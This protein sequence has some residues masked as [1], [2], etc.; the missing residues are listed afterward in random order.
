M[1]YALLKVLRKLQLTLFNERKFF[2]QLSQ[3]FYLV[4]LEAENFRG[5]VILRLSKHT[6]FEKSQ[7]L[8]NKIRP[9]HLS[10]F[11]HKPKRQ[12]SYSILLYYRYDMNMMMILVRCV[13]FLMV[14]LGDEEEVCVREGRKRS[15]E[16]REGEGASAEQ[17]RQK[18]ATI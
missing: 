10:D 15:Y 7:Y 14:R 8:S 3:Y 11:F 2:C 13:L 16:G 6:V 17:K 1:Q 4:D 18:L 12:Y 5:C 9:T